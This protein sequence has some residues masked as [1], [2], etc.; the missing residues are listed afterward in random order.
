MCTTRGRGLLSSVKIFEYT[1]GT[2]IMSMS[3]PF[4][5]RTSFCPVKKVDNYWST[6]MLATKDSD[7]NLI[8]T[9]TMDTQNSQTN[10]NQTYK[11]IYEPTSQNPK[12]FV[13]VL[14]LRSIVTIF[15]RKS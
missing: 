6:S 5:T 9:R 15:V 11:P 10:N 1:Q 12:I 8:P 2:H 4:P 13:E 14:L 3:H 7:R